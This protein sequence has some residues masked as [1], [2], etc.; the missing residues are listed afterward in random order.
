[1]DSP[2]LHLQKLAY[3]DITP[4]QEPV[5]HASPARA[6]A[7]GRRPLQLGVV[8]SVIIGC[9]FVVMRASARPHAPET[10]VAPRPE[11]IGST[12]PAP[13]PVSLPKS[14]PRPRVPALS[15]RPAPA[16]SATAMTSTPGP[17]FAPATIGSMPVA[18]TPVVAPA[19]SA[20]APD[21]TPAIEP[22]PA[23]LDVSVP[24]VPQADSLSNLPKST[25]DSVALARILR[26]VGGARPA[27]KPAP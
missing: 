18:K 27:Q 8:A 21:S 15:S 10:V 16:S 19:K 7:G 23:E 3:P 9:T 12:R 17:A 24:A 6:H 20:A 25:T 1:V 11:S 2:V 13:A 4:A 26:A 14:S 5:A 22:P